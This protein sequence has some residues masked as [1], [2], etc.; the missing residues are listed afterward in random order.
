MRR[1]RLL[2]VLGAT[3]AV[4]PF[5]PQA[6]ASAGTVSLTVLSGRAD[7]VAGGDALVQV[8][9]PAGARLTV[10]LGTRP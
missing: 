7:Q 2:A 5:L 4:I 3:A 9:A 6:S 1:S 8:T 10:T